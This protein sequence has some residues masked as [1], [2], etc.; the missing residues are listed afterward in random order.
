MIATGNPFLI[1]CAGIASFIPDVSPWYQRLILGKKKE[2]IDWDGFYTDAHKLTW[3]NLLIPFWN[4]HILEDWLMHKTNGGWKWWGI[5]L[6][7]L[8]WCIMAYRIF[9]LYYS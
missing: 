3:Y 5:Y 7:I 2:D 4:L 1:A 6:E 9:Y 8:L